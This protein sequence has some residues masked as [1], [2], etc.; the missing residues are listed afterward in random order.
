MGRR[1]WCIAILEL[2]LVS[3]V[4]F[5]IYSHASLEQEQPFVTILTPV[6]GAIPHPVFAQFIASQTLH[7]NTPARIT[8]L[9]IPLYIPAHAEQIKILLYQNDH[10]VTWWK[11]PIDKQARTISAT[12]YVS[13]PFVSPTTLSGNLKVV[14]DGTNIPYLDRAFAPGFFIEEQDSDYPEGNYS[15]ADNQ[16]NGDIGMQFISQQTNSELFWNQFHS[17]PVGSMS[18]LFIFGAG[19]VLLLYMPILCVN[20]VEALQSKSQKRA[21]S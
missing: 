2:I 3:I 20:L 6:K 14:F 12:E 9:I 8:A 4:V 13:L 16:K 10:L 17:E 11:Y 15:I 1:F 19:F 7:W 21:R 18:M 5:F